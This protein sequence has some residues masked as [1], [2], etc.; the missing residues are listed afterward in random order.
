MSHE[1]R[2]PMNSI[3]GFAQLL[4]MG[5]LTEAQLKSVHHILRSGKHLLDLINEV[6]DIARIEAG[7]V[8]I[9][10]E[11]VSARDI[12][13]DCLDT[14]QPLAASKGI[15]IHTDVAAETFIRAD[16]QRLKQVLINIMNNAI[17]YNRNNGDVWIK[18]IPLPGLQS[19]M[20]KLV[21]KDSG[22]GIAEKDISKVFLPFERIG[23]ENH[24]IEGTGLGLAVVKQLTELMGG[25]V[26]VESE[27]GKGSTFWITLTESISELQRVK[28]NGDIHQIATISNSIGGTVLY[29]EDN[30]SNV[31]LIE[32]IVL[33]KR[34]DVKLDVV[35]YGK[36]ALPRALEIKPSLILLDLNLPD[37]HGSEVLTQLKSNV[38][39]SA[40]PV[41][42]ISADAMP[43]QITKLKES[44][45]AGYLTKPIELNELLKVIDNYLTQS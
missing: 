22:F 45:A 8:S 26:G 39:T 10:V 14:I 32:Q 24:N 38:Q 12:I 28:N 31:E 37:I 20:V 4:E 15:R 18:A 44:G 25:N 41:V 19:N 30:A 6:L 5:E 13:T 21:I 11:A 2:T 9:S 43:A 23:A 33:T 17:K 27:E 36:Q 34:K 7:R 42:V 16:K 29:V 35:M 40:I 3:L 1:L